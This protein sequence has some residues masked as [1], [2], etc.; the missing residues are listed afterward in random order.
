MGCGISTVCRYTHTH[1]L[2]YTQKDISSFYL[3]FLGPLP[4]LNVTSPHSPIVTTRFI[5]STSSMPIN[6]FKGVCDNTYLLCQRWY[7]SFT[8]LYVYQYLA[9]DRQIIHIHTHTH[10][11]PHIGHLYSSVLADTLT[12]YYAL[13]GADAFLCTGTDEHGLKVKERENKHVD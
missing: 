3:F 13:K 4:S 8:I 2:T 6:T 1:S 11:V 9:P 7:V 5:L 12:R 10:Q